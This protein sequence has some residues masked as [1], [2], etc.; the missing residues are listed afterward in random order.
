[1]QTQNPNI[2][3]IIAGCLKQNP[4][5]QKKLF[6]LYYA[7]IM[8]I[9]IRYCANSGEAKEMLNDTFYKVFKYINR[10]DSSYPFKPWLRKVCINTCL[11]YKRKYFLKKNIYP[12]ENIYS[13]ILSEPAFEIPE[14][15][16]LDYMRLLKDLPPACKTVINLFVIEEYKHHEIAEMLGI[17][18]GTSKSNLSRAKKLLYK[19]L[20]KDKNKRLKLKSNSDG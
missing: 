16:N 19:M 11:E 17:S 10:Y 9:C 2:K 3:L 1:M 20:E 14:G 13:E 8:S 7:Y 18:V 12:L 5:S 4:A 15:D 6:E